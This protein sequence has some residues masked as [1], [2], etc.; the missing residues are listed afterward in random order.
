MQDGQGEPSS[1]TLTLTVNGANDAA[2][3]GGQVAGSVTEDAIL[4]VDGTLTITDADAAQAAFTA[5]TYVGSFGS[6]DLTQAGAWTYTLANANATVQALSGGQSVQDIIGITS[7][8][9]TAQQIT[10]TING[11]N[12]PNGGNGQTQDGTSGPDQITTG[13]GNDVINTGGGDDTVV[14][15]NGSDLVQAGSGNDT[16]HGGTGSD[17]LY[18]DA[19]DDVLFGE[20]GTD[21]LRGGADNDSLIGG[22]GNDSFVFAAGFGS[23]T[24]SDFDFNPAGGGQDLLDI[25]AFGITSAT[26]ASRVGLLDLGSD[27]QVT[28][29]GDVNQSITLANVEL[30]SNITQSDFILS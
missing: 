28:I 29:D 16:V 15:G 11:Q 21:I 26:F 9:G 22:A 14:G 1:S 12:E 4:A 13:N 7:I 25:S 6:L 17:T 19:G 30:L 10:I 20:Q 27:I 5:G 18:G 2:I 3:I 23:D 8:D 24:I